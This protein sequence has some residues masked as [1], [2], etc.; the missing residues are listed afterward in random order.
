VAS[1]AVAQLASTG[2]TAGMLGHDPVVFRAE[3]GTSGSPPGQEHGA[4]GEE[5]DDHDDNNDGEL[6]GGYLLWRA[7]VKTETFNALRERVLPGHAGDCRSRDAGLRGEAARAGRLHTRAS[8]GL[9][10]TL[11]G[12][13]TVRGSDGNRRPDG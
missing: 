6:H 7:W 1:L 8:S 3:A 11:A 12:A 4:D 13:A 2:G 10:V 5:Q 9:V